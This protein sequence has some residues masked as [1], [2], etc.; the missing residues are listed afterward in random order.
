M[1]RRPEILPIDPFFPRHPVYIRDPYYDPYHYLNHWITITTTATTTTKPE[2]V[3]VEAL[4]A[5]DV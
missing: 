3:K 4:R 1:Y 2:P 5:E